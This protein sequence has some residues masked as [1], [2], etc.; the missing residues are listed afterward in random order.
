MCINLFIATKAY[1]NY[2]YCYKNIATTTSQRTN[3]VSKNVVN[4]S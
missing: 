4:L 1:I 3:L 2:W